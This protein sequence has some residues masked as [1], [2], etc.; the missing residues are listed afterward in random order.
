MPVIGYEMGP[1][2]A[3]GGVK[4]DILGVATLDKV[5]GW[6]NTMRSGRVG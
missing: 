6:S 5:R 4:F 3:T 2:E 1:L